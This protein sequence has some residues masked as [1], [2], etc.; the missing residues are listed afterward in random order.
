M[1]LSQKLRH[2]HGLSEAVAIMGTPQN[3]AILE[4]AGLLVADAPSAQSDDLLVV[5]AGKEQEALD[6]AISWAR[7]A[8]AERAQGASSEAAGRELVTRT[9]ASAA[10]K[11]SA[12]N[13]ALI[14]TPGPYAAAEA[15]KALKLGLHVMLFSSNVSLADEL[16]LKKLARARG[17]LLMGPDCG[18]AI[19]RGSPLGFANAVTRGPV[20]IVA[21]SGSGL[22]EL[23]CQL[24]RRGI[25]ISHAIGTGSRDLWREIGGITM[26]QGYEALLSDKST[27]L[28]IL[29][30]KPCH[31]DVAESVL[32]GFDVDSKPL[33]V[34]M[35]GMDAQ[36]VSVGRTQSRVRTIEAAAEAT[37]SML[38]GRLP[39]IG[40]MPQPEDEA[41]V[42]EQRALLSSS[43]HS[44]RGLFSGGTLCAEAIIT[45]LDLGHRVFSNVP[46][47][48]AEGLTQPLESSADTLLD[49]G[50]EEFTL[51][52]PHPMIDYGTRLDLLR[53]AA[54]TPSVGVVL[55]DIVLGYGA[56]PDP[57]AEFAP[58]VRAIRRKCSAEG[59]HVA[60][61]ASICGTTRDPQDLALQEAAF[62]K[63]GVLVSPTTS[64]AARL[65]HAL[66]HG[67]G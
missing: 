46:M 37:V 1:Q 9:I 13:L 26:R 38:N 3:K 14:S 23:T 6:A 5:V 34:C 36:Q 65:A 8:L 49:L 15:F 66:V 56:H 20:G 59:R 40:A 12:A 17:L 57:A 58:V 67:G 27:E 62:K 25:G 16:A 21:A 30:S 2:L 52:K 39:S 48:G 44:I 4:Q 7:A 32:S 31:P 43:Q 10:A 63:L 28:L 22:Q 41:A 54:S 29:L 45:L 51:G 50:A 55:L 60:I 35:L 42:R 18:T 47:A 64:H 19:L 24:D 11:W 53:D 61:V 33:V